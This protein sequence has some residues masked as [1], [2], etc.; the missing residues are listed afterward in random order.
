MMKVR[1]RGRSGEWDE[2][3]EYDEISVTPLRSELISER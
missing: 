2:E 3:V 1:K